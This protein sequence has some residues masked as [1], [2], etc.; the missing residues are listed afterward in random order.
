LLVIVNASP[1]GRTVAVHAHGRAEW[2]RCGSERAVRGALAR[3]L[4]NTGK[5][6][7]DMGKQPKKDANPKT[8]AK[9]PQGKKD[10]P[11]GKR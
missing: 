2:Y 7:I 11:A 4:W 3:M 8:E 1:D 6:V 9:K 10:K 5:G